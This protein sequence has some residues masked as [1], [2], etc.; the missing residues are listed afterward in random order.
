MASPNAFPATVFRLK[1]GSERR[2]L[3]GHP[4][5]YSNEIQ[6]SPKGIEPGSPVQ[7][8]DAAGK[9][10]A[11]GYGNPHSLIFARVLSR[12]PERA[13]FSEE[14]CRRTIAQAKG[15]REALGLAG[16]SYRLLFGES[17]GIPGLVVDR[18]V[19]AGGA[20]AAL[21]LQAHSAGA[22][23]LLPYVLKALE[24]AYADEWAKTAVVIR[25]DLVVRKLEGLAEEEPKALK[26]IPGVDLSK[27]EILARAWD[28]KPPFRFRADLLTGQ[29]TGFFLDQSENVAQVARILRQ[30]A[31]A[32]PKKP[33]IL[34]LCCYVGQWGVKLGV[35][36]REVGL[37]PK[38]T[39]ADASKTA[40][41]LAK[42]NAEIAEVAAETAEMDVL[43]DLS[44]VATD[45]YDVVVC[46]PPALIKGRKDLPT[47]SHAYLKLNTEAIRL[48]K[49]GGII[50]SCS[51][52][53][54][55]E[56]E[57]L[58]EILAKASKRAGKTV[59][60][61]ARGTQAFDHPQRLEFPEGKYLKMWVGRVD[62]E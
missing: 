49:P 14:W 18:F 35:A 32:L 24:S 47:G 19:L 10:I 8:S 53:Q 40:L 21:V 4:W 12:D 55:M 11:Y 31:G 57:N 42:A 30:S 13:P 6:G 3:G 39:F 62:T 46:D 26:E 41:A 23:Q 1:K 38:V 2:V 45:S 9:F 27:V 54:L 56:E 5:I 44:K 16:A 59:R 34:D 48:T 51:C 20:G 7:I 25:N 28:G 37:A 29:K 43:Q 50:L 17:D 60:W 58:K 33:A 15:F 36:L 61:F 22:Q 52:S